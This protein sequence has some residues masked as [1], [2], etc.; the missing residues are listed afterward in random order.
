MGFLYNKLL[1]PL[2]FTDYDGLPVS[3]K[4]A[5]KEA[6]AI[7][8]DRARPDPFEKAG[9]FREVPVHFYYPEPDEKDPERFPLVVFSHGAFGFYKSNYS[10]YAELASNGYVVAA[11]DHPHH[12]FFTK[13]T[14]GKRVFVDKAF[15]RAATG[16]GGE[17]DAQKEYEL[18]SGWVALRTSDVSFVID[19]LKAAAQSGE[20][21]SSWFVSEP[22]GEAARSVPQLLDASRIGV[23]GHSLGGAAAVEI[24]RQRRDVS[25][26]IDLDGTM[27]GEYTGAENG[28]LTFREDPFPVPVLEFCGWDQYNKVLEFLAQGEC[29]PNDV[30]IRSAAAGFS[31]TLRGTKHMDF[32]DLPLFSPF[33]GK[34][35]GKGER[36][37]AEALQIV[38]SLALE[39]L[40][41]YLKGEGVFTVEPIY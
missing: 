12:A 40:N 38:N 39:F 6:S 37:T 15:F 5:V 18:Y 25:A 4:H 13:N 27:L 9:G 30:L 3:G 32:T 22:E 21:D 23:M 10:T 14:R 29:Y 7:L 19:A 34:K 11:L 1:K 8:I 2:L 24:G 17:L 36:D 33:L 41:C 35:L 28:K 26:V 20:T 31:T 16:R